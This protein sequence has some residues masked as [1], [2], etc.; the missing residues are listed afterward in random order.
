MIGVNLTPLLA[1]ATIIGATLGFGAQL[2]IRD[3]LSGSCS[4]SRINT[5]SA[6]PSP[7]A[8]S[9]VWSRT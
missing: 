8:R 9:A 6:T 1:S 3:Y 7:S 4:P 5:A 2:I